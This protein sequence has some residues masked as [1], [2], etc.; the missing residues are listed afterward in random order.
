MHATRERSPGSV[1]AGARAVVRA[2]TTT[3]GPSSDH[4]HRSLL[5]AALTRSLSLSPSP[6]SPLGS[7]CSRSLNSSSAA[8]LPSPS[9]FPSH[10]LSL[11]RRSACRRRQHRLCSPLCTSSCLASD[12]HTSLSLLRLSLSC[13]TSRSSLITIRR[14]QVASAALSLPA[15]PPLLSPQPGRCQHGSR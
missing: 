4:S 6:G 11:A 8:A 15:L 1:V 3:T 12:R 5:P 9:A 13:P 2:T 14:Q 7:P 10:S